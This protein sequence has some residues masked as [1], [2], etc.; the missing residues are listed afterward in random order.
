MR[1]LLALHETDIA[2]DDVVRTF[3]ATPLA[4]D[5]EYM[6]KYGLCSCANYCYPVIREL[7]LFEVDVLEPAAKVFERELAALG[8]TGMNGSGKLRW[9]LNKFVK[10]FYPHK[11]GCIEFLDST[12]VSHRMNSRS[13]VIFKRPDEEFKNNGDFK[14]C[15][16]CGKKYPHEWV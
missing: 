13:M 2:A 10:W 8:I 6:E 4:I 3:H 1:Y 9:I 15:T 7:R 11:K 12:G 14:T 5:K 16:N